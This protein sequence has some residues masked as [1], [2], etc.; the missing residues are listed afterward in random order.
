VVDQWFNP[1]A[2]TSVTQ[3]SRNFAGTAARGIMDGPGLMNFDLGLF[4]EFRF[5]EKRRLQFRCEAT[6]GFNLVNLSNPGTGANNA[7]TFGRITTARPMRQ[8]QLGLRLQL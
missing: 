8:V 6:N 2:F 5:D 3:A 7:A 4:R 1:T